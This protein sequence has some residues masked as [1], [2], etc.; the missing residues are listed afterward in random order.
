MGAPSLSAKIWG[1]AVTRRT[2][3]NGSTIPTQ[4]PTSN[5]K[6]AAMGL[7]GIA[8]LV[9][10]YSPRPARQGESC[11]VL[12]RWPTPAAFSRH[13]Q[14]V[15]FMLQGKNAANKATDGCVWTF[16]VVSPKLH[17]NNCSSADLPSDSL[18]ENLAWWAVTR[19]T[20]QTTKPSKLGGGRLHGYGRLLGTIRYFKFSAKTNILTYDD[21]LQGMN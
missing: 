13:L 3:L 12:Q 17:Q 18:R 20:L 8:S 1:W 4:G 15:N 16:D 10:P 6:L 19:R 5:V 7:N 9:H 11:I 21:T 14:Y 2:H